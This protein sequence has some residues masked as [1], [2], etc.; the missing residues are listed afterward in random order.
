LFIV[1]AGGFILSK[2]GKA[3][4]KKEGAD[5]VIWIVWLFLAF[6]VFLG[7]DFSDTGYRPN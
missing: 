6:G 5:A 2:I 4:T 7:G 1:I 3:I